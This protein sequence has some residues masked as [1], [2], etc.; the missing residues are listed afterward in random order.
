MAGGGRLPATGDGL[1]ALTWA[2]VS[3]AGSREGD[4]P[5]GLA[6]YID[7]SFGY[8]ASAPKKPFNKIHIR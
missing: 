1:D 3:L 5:K 7:P 8:L 4:P 6:N 2:R